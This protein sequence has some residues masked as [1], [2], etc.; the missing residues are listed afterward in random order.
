MQQLSLRQLFAGGPPQLLQ[1]SLLPAGHAAGPQGPRLLLVLV[2]WPR[3]AATVTQTAALMPLRQLM[4]VM[5]LTWLHQQLLLILLLV[6]VVLTT[7]GMPAGSVTA[8]ATVAMSRSPLQHSRRLPAGVARLLLQANAV[9]ALAR[10][11]LLQLLPLRVLGPTGG[12]WHPATL[13]TGASEGAAADSRV[14]C[15]AQSGHSR[16]VL[17]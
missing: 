5:A 9:P 7:L 3:A 17:A 12:P 15:R 13:P 1:Q 8:A 6:V 2:T 11:G 4:K 16:T 14:V 10:Q